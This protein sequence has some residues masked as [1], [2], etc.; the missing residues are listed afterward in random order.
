M[1]TLDP[2]ALLARLCAMPAETAWI[3]FKVNNTD[4]DM[5]GKWV[6]ACANAVILHDQENGFLVFGVRDRTHERVGT[7]VRLS[8]LRRGND[9]FQNWLSRMVEPRINMEFL[10]F[11]SEGKAF[12]IIRIEPAYD[13]PVRFSGTEYIR[14]GENTKKLAEYPE[15]ERAL[16]LATGRRRFEDAVAKPHQPPSNVVQLLDVDSFYRLCREEQPRNQ[17]EVMRRLCTQGFI[18]NDMEGCYDITNLGAVLF[19]NNLSDFPSVASKGVRIIA[20]VGRDKTKALDEWESRQGYAVA[21]ASLIRHTIGKLPHDEVYVDGIRDMR[22]VHPEDAVREVIANALIHQDFT[23]SGASPMVEL[24][25]DRL[26]VTNPGNSLIEVDRIIDERRSRN[27]KLAST[28]RL[29]GL[30][31][32]RGGGLDKAV[33]AIERSNLPA[34]D[35]NPSGNSMRVTLFGPRPFS[36]LSKADRSRACFFHCVIRWL[37]GDYMSNTTLRQRFDLADKD[38][39][40]VSAIISEAVRAGRIV[41]AEDGQSNRNAKYVPYWARER[42]HLGR[43]V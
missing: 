13:R 7:D 17:A 22:P 42:D 24:Y 34:P 9:N 26:D 2:A 40:A 11:E 37:M 15:Q 19:A 27:E 29:L 20:Y 31:E 8:Q 16:W 12:A 33:I 25:S 21:F 35:F 5:I 4:P 14:I 18:R 38:Y 28:M 30:C 1:A 36:S 6:S 32:L 39:Q 3:E 23:I 41:A 43:R 10:D